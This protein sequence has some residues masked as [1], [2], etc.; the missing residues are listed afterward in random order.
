MQQSTLNPTVRLISTNDGLEHHLGHCQ[1]MRF[2]K[3]SEILDEADLQTAGIFKKLIIPA[4]HDRQG[5]FAGCCPE[6]RSLD[7]MHDP[8]IPGLIEKIDAE[9]V[10]ARKTSAVPCSYIRDADTPSDLM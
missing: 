5:C 10:K 4:D 2:H 3:I 6:G 9:Q 1:T 7:K 8:P